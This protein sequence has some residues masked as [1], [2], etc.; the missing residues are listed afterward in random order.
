MNELERDYEYKYMYQYIRNTNYNAYIDKY[1]PYDDCQ[2]I[3]EQVGHL[4]PP[5]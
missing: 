2:F 5:K 3:K 4:T 1:F